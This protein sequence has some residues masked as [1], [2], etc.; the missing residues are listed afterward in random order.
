MTSMKQ[1]ELQEMNYTQLLSSCI[2]IAMQKHQQL[3]SY[4][5]NHKWKIDFNKGLLYVWDQSFPISWIGNEQD[6]GKRWLWGCNQYCRFSSCVIDD[7]FDFFLSPTI[8]RLPEIKD[9]EILTNN[10]VNGKNIASIMSCFIDNSSYFEIEYYRG[11]GYVLVKDLMK[12]LFVA[13]DAKALKKLIE[14][15]IQTTEVDHYVLVKSVLD[16]NDKFWIL[17]ENVIQTTCLK[18]NLCFHFKDSKIN[19]ITIEN[20]TY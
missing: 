11:R 18:D 1:I 2:G 5:S 15:I 4:F 19:R 9:I 3:L 20:I 16:F 8:R 10:Q 14:D 7:T 12:E 13:L 17:K 6:T